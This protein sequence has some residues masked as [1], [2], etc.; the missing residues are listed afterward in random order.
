MINDFYKFLIIVTLIAVIE[1][2]SIASLK[3]YYISSKIRYFVISVI[4]YIIICYL[5][6]LTFKYQGIGICNVIWSA[7]SIIMVI[8]LGI[9]FFKEN[10]NLY[11]GFG[12][13]LV[14]S[15]IYIIKKNEN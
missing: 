12:S 14:I 13:I 11:D 9:L 6:T 7:I 8:F 5:L 4:L 1:S 15:G 3:E 2:F 10:I